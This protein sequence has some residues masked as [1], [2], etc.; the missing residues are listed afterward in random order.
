M[1]MKLSST[2]FPGGAK[3]PVKYTCDGADLSPPLSWSAAPPA[4]RSFA[5]VCADPDAPAGT[6][7]HWAVYDIPADMTA[8]PEDH[9]P[10]Q[11]GVMRDATNDFG[12]AGYGGPCPPRGHGTHRY[13]FTV[14]ALKVDRLPLSG[15]PRCRDVE[16]AA[17]ANALDHATL[18]GV[19]AR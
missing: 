11:G 17:K 2:A 5:L 10:G 7:Y 16:R 1:A 6:W 8:L 12:R 9:S 19:Y 15:K 13:A 14:Y 3:V 18:I 4:T